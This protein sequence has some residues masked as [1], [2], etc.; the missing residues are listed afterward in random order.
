[1]TPLLTERSPTIS[2]NRVDRLQR[3]S[4]AAAKQCKLFHS[5]TK[6]YFVH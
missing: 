3:V 1:M 5:N 6:M 4:F 2:E